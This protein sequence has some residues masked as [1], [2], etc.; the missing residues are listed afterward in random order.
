MLKADWK[1]TA[2]TTGISVLSLL[3]LFYLAIVYQSMV[4]AFLGL[5]IAALVYLLYRVNERR[6]EQIQRNEA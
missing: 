5:L 4:H 1:S 2:L 6:L 3:L